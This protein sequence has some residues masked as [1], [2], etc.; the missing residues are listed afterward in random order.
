MLPNLYVSLIILIFILF[1]LIYMLPITLYTTQE[2]YSPFECG[3]DPSHHSRS[4]FSLQFFLI[5]LIFLIFDV[6]ITLL[7]PMPLIINSLSYQTLIITFFTIMAIL[8]VG[9]LYEWKKGAL[10]WII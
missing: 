8:T 7:L 9:L 5:A 2:F 10:S 3:F 4:P 6:E 1:L